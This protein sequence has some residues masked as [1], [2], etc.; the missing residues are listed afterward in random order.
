MQGIITK[1][2]G[3][4]Y[5]VYI[6]DKKAELSARLK[7]IFRTEGNR[8]TNPIAVGDSVTIEIELDDYVIASIEERKNY[9]I[10]QSPKRKALR[11]IIA[12]NIDLAVVVAAIKRPRTST[13]FIDRFLVTTEAYRIPTLIIIN[14]V[15]DLTDKE[16]TILEDWVE[17]YESIGYDVLTTSTI[18]GQGVEELKDLL[19]NKRSLFSGHSGVG[20]SSLLNCIE[21][22]LDL[23]TGEIS[24]IHEK[25][26][27]TTTFSELFRLEKLN[28]E[29]IDTPGIKEFGVLHTEDYEVK[30]FF[31]EFVPYLNQCKFH[32]CMHINE[33]DCKVLEALEDGKISPWRYQNYL[34][35]LEDIKEQGSSWELKKRDWVKR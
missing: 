22:S 16:K 23:R 18:T 7:G 15:D 29:I 33:P 3:T 31:I 28:A 6:P 20:K 2:T 26:M 27:H 24:K 11:H 13:G 35:I 14:K 10:R 5:Q 19:K 32:N 17:T 8:D 1:S 30:D 9:V 4:W 21:P 34:G 12:S 25:G